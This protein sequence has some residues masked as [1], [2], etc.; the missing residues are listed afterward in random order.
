MKLLI[1]DDH[2]LMRRLIRRVVCDLVSD[3][4][5]CGDGS[6]ALAAYHQYRPDWVVM[7]IE[8]SRMD[9]ITATR[10]ILEAFPAAR[11]V[12]VS[13]HDDEHIREAAQAAGACGYV[14]KENLLAIR[15]LLESCSSPSGDTLERKGE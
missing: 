6:E 13:K 2:S 1:I 3:V 15:T 5:E 11:I 4:E 10:E 9:G 14:L 7:D 8:M 12:I